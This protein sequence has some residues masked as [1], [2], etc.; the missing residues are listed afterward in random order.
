MKQN[1]MYILY[2]VATSIGSL[3]CLEIF[4]IFQIPFFL[5]FYIKSNQSRKV[6]QQLTYVQI[7]L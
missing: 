1:D 5:P 4:N 6:T 2:L 7:T 3:C